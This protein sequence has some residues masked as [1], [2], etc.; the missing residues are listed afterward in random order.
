MNQPVLVLALTPRCL[1]SVIG[2]RIRRQGCALTCPE[3]CWTQGGLR[4][5]AG[6][7]GKGPRKA[8]QPLPLVAL[9]ND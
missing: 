6:S 7:R 4:V 9:Q 5:E 8:N 1:V 3:G 2:A